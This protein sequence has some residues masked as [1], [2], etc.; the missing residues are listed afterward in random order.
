MTWI[1]GIIIVVY[2]AAVVVAGIGGRGRQENTRDYFTSRDGFKGRIGQVIVGLSI[3]ATLFSGI[4]LVAIPS[5]FYAYGVTITAVMISFP[6]AYLLLRYW[7]L[8]RY[9]AVAQNS[10]YDIIEIQFGRPTRL[11]ASG[12][13]LLLR[14]AWMAALTYVPVLVIMAGVGLGHEW[15]WPLILFIGLSST[16][17]TVA[18]GIR[19]VIITDAI[20][21]I[22][23]IVVLLAIILFIGLRLPM[24]FAEVSGYLQGNTAL[25]KLNWSLNPTVA[26]T[27]LAMGIGG[28]FSNMSSYIA[29]QMSLQRYLASGGVRP[30]VSAFGS[31]M[32]STALI[33]VLLY[34][35]GLA[36]GAWYHIHPDSG[37][38]AD[39]DR[40]FPYFVASQLPVGFM[41]LTLAA[42]LA[43]TMSSITS[44]IN[45]LSGSLLN[46]FVPLVERVESRRLLL[47]A[48]LTSAA[49]GIGTTIG[50]GFV[51]RVGSL[52][53]ILFAFFG[54]FLGP[55]LACMICTIGRLQATG[56]ILIPAML[57]GCLSGVGV[58]T[59]PIADVW[60]PAVTCLVTLS[61]AWLGS[62]IWR[63]V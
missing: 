29:D 24:S 17:Y 11:V 34:A 53:N 19:G 33:F 31:C 23:I 56:R 36:I 58:A 57:L 20:Q 41:G 63:K 46:D 45:A 32:V 43:A 18:G 16:A 7:F 39:A 12:M 55:L 48:R 14:L 60:M 62:R 2:M 52:Y 3:G 28:T 1:D 51:E 47:Y 6:L 59:T 42:I 10:P 27:V 54:I 4:S 9:L 25:L 26:M 49:I 50:A 38:P 35:V 44:G 21:F 13:F 8:P 5:L 15:F 40:V 61:A 22:I 37:L 30:A